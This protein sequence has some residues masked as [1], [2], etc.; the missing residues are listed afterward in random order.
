M[1]IGLVVAYLVVGGL[2]AFVYDH[3]ANTDPRS[4]GEAPATRASRLQFAVTL[5]V[6][7]LPALVVIVVMLTLA[8]VLL[9][10]RGRR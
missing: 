9:E 6:L 8:I 10:G 4:P 3:M 5:A 1:S 7:W 2:V